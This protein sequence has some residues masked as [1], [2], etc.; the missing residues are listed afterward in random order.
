MGH[1]AREVALLPRLLPRRGGAGRVAF[2]PS[3]IRQGAAHLRAYQVA[4]GLEQRG[5]RTLVVPQQL[6]KIQRERVLS[7]FRPDL[8]VA[9]TCRHKLNRREHLEKF[10]YI[11]DL[12]D[13]DF[14]NP[15]LKNV[16]EDF[17]KGAVGVIAGSRFI[18]SWAQKFNADTSV[19]WTGNQI[20]AVNRKPQADRAP[21]VTWA[22]ADPAGYPA[23]FAFIADIAKRLA[24]TGVA[25]QLRLYGLPH[26]GTHPI[27]ED[28]RAQGITVETL[29][30]MD[31]DAF[32]NSLEDVAVGWS[33][34]IPASDF[35]KG[36]SFGK[37]LGDLDRHVPVICSDE[38][39]HGLFFTPKTGVVSNDPLVWV[40][41]TAKLLGDA[42]LR[43]RMAH[44][45][46]EDYRSRLSLDAVIDRTEDFLTRL[47][48]KQRAVA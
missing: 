10:N 1:R 25:F 48:T 31:Y 47:M 8:V 13:A 46:F 14:L 30:L 12:D 19:I 15:A 37:I 23:E 40:T 33:A 18:N 24:A 21:I 39:D 42:A 20:S 32:L 16:M 34:L 11:L 5:F 28:L 4:D 38:A 35:S 7:L 3:D 26:D 44:Q 36:K 27:V 29:P 6:E 41:E 22:Q 9:Q 17:A 45:A 2:L 43:S